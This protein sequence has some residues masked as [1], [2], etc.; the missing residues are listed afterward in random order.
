MQYLFISFYSIET[1]I[2]QEKL[3]RYIS[4]SY[5]SAIYYLYTCMSVT[6]EGSHSDRKC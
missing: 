5:G 2:I 4:Y 3:N 6:N 1:A